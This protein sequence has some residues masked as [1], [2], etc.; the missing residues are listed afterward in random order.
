[1]KIPTLRDIKRILNNPELR[2][3]NEQRKT[4]R[5]IK[6]MTPRDMHTVVGAH[7]NAVV[8]NA[9]LSYADKN[10]LERKLNNAFPDLRVV[11]EDFVS[12]DKYPLSPRRV[13]RT[14]VYIYNKDAEGTAV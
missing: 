8:R 12:V 6:I 14:C 7:P 11:V 5:R 4:F 3:Y 9:N 13:K 10:R 1:M 2:C